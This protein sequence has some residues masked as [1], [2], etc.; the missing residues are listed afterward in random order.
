MIPC[1]WIQPPDSDGSQVL[2]A[3]LPITLLSQPEAVTDTDLDGL[4]RAL[5]GSDPGDQQHALAVLS[6][7]ALQRPDLV[8][9]QHVEAFLERTIGGKSSA[10]ERLFE[11]LA[12]QD[13]GLLGADP[14]DRILDAGRDVASQLALF[15][16]LAGWG[17]ERI[18]LRHLVRL[19]DRLESRDEIATF[20]VTVVERWS[21][22]ALELG[23]AGLMDEIEAAVGG[24]PRWA[25]TRRLLERRR[26]AASGGVIARHALGDVQP[27]L[28]DAGSGRSKAPRILVVQNLK[29]GQ[30]DEILRVGPLLSLLLAWNPTLRIEM[31]SRRQYLYDHPRVRTTSIED[32]DS[33]RDLLAQT[34]DG[35]VWL[36]EVFAPE[37][38]YLSWLPD[39]L[40]RRAS[41]AGLVI[42]AATQ[43]N[44]LFFRRLTIGGV[45]LLPDLLPARCAPHDAFESLQLLALRLGLPWLR[46]TG[47]EL[48]RPFVGRPSPEAE[49]WI[50]GLHGGSSRPLAVVQPFGGHAETKGYTR[51]QLDLLASELEALAGEGYR[52]VV[53]PSGT[54]WASA[55][56]IRDVFDRMA[57]ALRRNCAV[58]PDPADSPTDLRE[59]PELDS[60]DRVMRRFKYL[61]QAADLVVAVEGW[62]CHL[63]ALLDRPV[64][65]V[66]WAGSFTPDWYPRG[67]VWCAGLSV[68]APHQPVEISTETA[69]ACVLPLSRRGLLEVAL[70]AA[71]TRDDA[72]VGLLLALAASPDPDLRAMALRT[73]TPLLEA[74]ALRDAAA[75]ALADPAAAV[76]AAA[77]GAWLAREDLRIERTPPV[78]TL[79][80][81]QA[82]G[83]EDWPAVLACGDAA[84]PALAIAAKGEAGFIRRQA[85]RVLQALLSQR[86]KAARP[87]PRDSPP[88]AS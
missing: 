73:A 87:G 51:G 79:R 29:I 49:R 40:K 59:R 24:H 33:V 27:L 80:A 25:Y 85:R 28:R 72:W 5:C 62:A 22:G 18:A 36:D 54:P 58:A 39:V 42:E 69:Q 78:A 84:L 15:T 47:S 77:A 23:D 86:A 46:E 13:D 10:A 35:F 71:S 64:R 67:A 3:E 61:L 56:V 57:P 7:L 17:P 32:T 53:L 9:G 20:L 60:A 43:H 16:I 11:G 31:V 37:I 88:A 38:R 14:A 1:A 30:G 45:D 21:W 2:S 74:G 52:L 48:Q 76:R 81:H 12:A 55:D 19:A 68:A 34:L 66:L 70:S 63:G 44:H 6:A 4:D 50:D 82:I 41:G 83:D 26:Q 75:T 65:M 8:D